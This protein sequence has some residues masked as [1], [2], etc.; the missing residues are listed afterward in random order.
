MKVKKIIWLIAVAI[1]LYSSFFFSDISQ[2]KQIGDT[3][4]YLLPN[5]NA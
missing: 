4:F 3:H 1:L 2:Y 5:F